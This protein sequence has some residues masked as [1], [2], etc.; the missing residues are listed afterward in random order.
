MAV[1]DHPEFDHH[2]QVLFC[3][4]AATGLR[5]IIAIHSTALGPAAGG[6]RVYPYAT[7]DD[8]LTDVLRLSRGMSYKNALADLPLG[9]GKGVIVADASDP[10]KA[11]LLRAFARHVQSLGGRYWTAIDVGIGPADADILAEECDYVFTRA[12]QYPDGFNPAHFTALGGFV[13]IRAVAKHVFGRDDLEG[14][15]VAVQGLG[16]T[17]ADLCRRLHEAG[18]VLTVADVNEDAVRS[19]VEAYGATVV[20]PAE[21]HA[22]DVD[23]FAPCALGA[24]LNDETIP[25]I[26]AKAVSGLANNQL[27]EPRHGA[28]LRDRGVTYV[29]DYV[30]NAGGIMGSSTV[31]FT[32]P[33]REESIRRIEGLYDTILEI[34]GQAEAENR[35]PSEVADELA[36]ARMAGVHAER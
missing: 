32:T 27:A 21:I 18:A 19:V 28:E 10:N 33:N 34:L 13:G 2:E 9:G 16:N 26:Q 6:C 36:R 11:E 4:D 20:D 24:V 25:Q 1:F 8:A 23:V 7:L 15:R 35:P 17:G 3:H 14:L 29:P 22:A 30:V 12:S 31:I 5:G